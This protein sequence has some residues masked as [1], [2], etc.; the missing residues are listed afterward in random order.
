MKHNTPIAEQLNR[1]IDDLSPELEQQLNARVNLA[2]SGTRT[3]SN[4][5]LSYALAPLALVVT[6]WSSMGENSDLT[7]EQQG[8]YD[9]LEYLIAQD[10]LDFLEDKGFDLE[11]VDVSNSFVA[12]VP[13]WNGMDVNDINHVHL[14]TTVDH[15]SHGW[16]EDFLHARGWKHDEERGSTLYHDFG[17]DE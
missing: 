2:K 6:I 10:E 12:T 5:R 17:G 8:I 16:I 14:E 1:S 4:R 15:D 9:D 3:S 13:Y 11:W 7:A